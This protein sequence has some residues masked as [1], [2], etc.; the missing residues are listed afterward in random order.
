MK[1]WLIII[2]SL[3]AVK[4]N[5]QECKKYFSKEFSL[6]TDNDVYLLNLKDGYYTNGIFL[7]YS[8]ASEKMGQKQIHRF[9]LGQ[10]MFT[11]GDKKAVSRNEEIIDR[12]Y[13][14]YLF[15]KYIHEQ[16]IA[17]ETILSWNFSLAVTGKWSLAQQLQESYHK[18][19]HLKPYPFWD[20]QIPNTIGFNAGINYTKTLASTSIAKMVAVAEANAGMYH[21]NAKVAAY[22]C[23]G[24]FEKNNGSALFNARAGATANNSKRK[25]ELF[26]YFHPQL[27]AQGYNAT[28]Q[29]TLF[30]KT[31]NAVTCKPQT[32]MYQ[33]T[34]GIAYAAARLTGKLE[35][36]YQTKEASTQNRQQRYAGIHLAYLFN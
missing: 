3:T 22:F 14:G 21:N 16:F 33:Q 5:A 9:A 32:F 24:A 29:G 19:I 15:A 35:A 34:W 23:M 2:A 31:N 28:T 11:T 20:T 10:T 12:P 13:C 1:H 6:Q 36:T 4:C 30:Y 18:L 26:F 17:A 27:I 8:M 25:Y 7:Q